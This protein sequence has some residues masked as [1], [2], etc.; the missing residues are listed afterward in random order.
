MHLVGLAVVGLNLVR[1]KNLENLLVFDQ[2][3]SLFVYVVGVR[4]EN[5][6]LCLL[7]SLGCE[8]AELL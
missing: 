5:H 3:A 4:V 7:E 1:L 2:D 6:A 8:L